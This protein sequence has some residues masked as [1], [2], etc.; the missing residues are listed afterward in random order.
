MFVELHLGPLAIE[1]CRILIRI[2]RRYPRMSE[3]RV[4]ERGLEGYRLKWAGQPDPVDRQE[5]AEC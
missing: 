3:K 5:E 2:A 4:I 1:F